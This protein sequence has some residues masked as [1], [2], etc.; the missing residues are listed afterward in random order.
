MGNHIP[1]RNL[2]PSSQL[3]ASL[4]NKPEWNVLV[5]FVQAAKHPLQKRRDH[6]SPL[7]W[8]LLQHLHGDF[9]KAL[10]LQL[11]VKKSPFMKTLEHVFQTSQFRQ[12]LGGCLCDLNPLVNRV[13]AHHRDAVRRQTHVEFESVAAVGQCPLEGLDGVFR[14]RSDGPC[15]AMPQ[16]QRH[17]IDGWTGHSSVEIEIPNRLAR[18]RRLF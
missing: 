15:P 3:L 9:L 12:L 11:D 10:N 18:V 1:A 5:P 14:D 16:K 2:Y 7:R 17:G 8:R 13:M 6:K 4:T